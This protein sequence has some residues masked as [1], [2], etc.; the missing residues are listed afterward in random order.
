MMISIYP[1]RMR[2]GSESEL[3]GKTLGLSMYNPTVSKE[4]AEAAEFKFSSTRRCSILNHR[5]M[6][7]FRLM[8]VHIQ[9]YTLEDEHLSITV[10]T[11][12]LR[13]QLILMNLK[14]RKSTLHIAFLISDG[15]LDEVTRQHNGKHETL[16]S[17]STTSLEE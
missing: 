11:G 2:G 15:E 12:M 4:E 3:E 8:A 14:V 13:C 9:E 7:H 17:M 10:E 1:D 16:V 6:L 5:K